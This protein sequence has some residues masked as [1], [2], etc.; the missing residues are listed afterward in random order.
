MIGFSCQ[1]QKKER[2]HQK[3]KKNLESKKH[4]LLIHQDTMPL[5]GPELV[6]MKTDIDWLPPVGC[7][8]IKGDR[9]VVKKLLQNSSCSHFMDNQQKL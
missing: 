7:S 8:D 4:Q 2:N 3:K 9:K 1:C 5:K 6:K